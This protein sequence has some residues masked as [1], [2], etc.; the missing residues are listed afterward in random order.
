MVHSGVEDV[1]VVRG[2]GDQGG[3]GVALSED[4][5]LV[6]RHTCNVSEGEGGA[7]WLRVNGRR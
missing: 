5:E 1:L 6:S 4:V 3:L 7:S 2:L